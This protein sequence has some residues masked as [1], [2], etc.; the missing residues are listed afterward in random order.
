MLFVKCISLNFSNNFK[1][2]GVGS[3]PVMDSG[4]IPTFVE[5]MWG[6]PSAAIRFVVNGTTDG[7]GIKIS[8]QV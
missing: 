8:I 5:D 6:N 4:S 1:P 3:D 2:S 7:F